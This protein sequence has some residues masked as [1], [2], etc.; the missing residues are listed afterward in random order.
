MKKMHNVKN[1]HFT[2]EYLLVNI[3]GQEL[4]FSLLEISPKLAAASAA[5]R[6]AY[7]VMA[8]GYGINW[9][10]LDEDLPIDGLPGIKHMPPKHKRVRSRQTQMA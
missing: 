8:S 4:S 1:I 7:R 5:E 3:D 6:E 10:L 9:P 2:D